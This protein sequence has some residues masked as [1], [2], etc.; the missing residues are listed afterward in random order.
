[1]KVDTYITLT[2]DEIQNSIPYPVIAEV[3]CGSRWDTGR[4]KRLLKEEFSEEEMAKIK[5]MYAQ[6]RKWHLVTGVP[7]EIQI[8]ATELFLWQKLAAFCCSI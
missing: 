1:M 8:K 2:R 7:E 3:V 6:A 5:P 4:T